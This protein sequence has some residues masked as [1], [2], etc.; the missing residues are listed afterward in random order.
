M[1]SAYAA[2]ALEYCA[3]VTRVFLASL[4]GNRRQ[5]IDMLVDR[6]KNELISTAIP[7]YLVLLRRKRDSLVDLGGACEGP[8]EAGR[9][10]R[11]CVRYQTLAGPVA[12]EVAQ[13]ASFLDHQNSVGKSENHGHNAARF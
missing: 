3:V 8:R 9:K 13:G 1:F 2:N 5:G 4:L 11:K 12:G 6:T 10:M 7:S